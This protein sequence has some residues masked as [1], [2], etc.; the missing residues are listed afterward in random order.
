MEKKPRAS[1]KLEL[2]P[3][4][5]DGSHSNAEDFLTRSKRTEFELHNDY[6]RT[7]IQLCFVLQ[8]SVTWPFVAL[9][10]M[11]YNMVKLHVSLKSETCKS[12]VKR[13]HHCLIC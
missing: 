4:A 8:Y 11:L 7:I 6:Q 10:C 1:T 13:L 5:D 2:L 12:V 3:E 9:V